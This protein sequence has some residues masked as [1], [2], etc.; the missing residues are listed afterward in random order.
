MGTWYGNA[1]VIDIVGQVQ[2]FN[3]AR[4]LPSRGHRRGGNG[5]KASDVVRRHHDTLAEAGKSDGSGFVR[6]VLGDTLARVVDH[7]EELFEALK[8]SVNLLLG[9]KTIIPGV[10]LVAP[11]EITPGESRSSCPSTT[12]RTGAVD[13][14]VGKQR[15][16]NEHMNLDLGR[17]CRGGSEVV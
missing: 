9:N 7:G 10:G 12:F 3:H 17:V 13:D 1:A 2:H 14:A 5:G 4:R 16:G 15:I 8:T 6:G 11:T